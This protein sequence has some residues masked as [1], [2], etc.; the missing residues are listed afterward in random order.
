MATAVS[1]R[2]SQSLHKVKR[3][4]PPSLQTSINAVNSSN[5]SPS[6]SLPKKTPSGLKHPPNSGVSNSI[7]VNSGGTRASGRQ[8]KEVQRPGEVYGR[9]YK[10]SVSGRGGSVDGID[11]DRRKYLK[12]LPPQ[13]YGKHIP[14]SCILWF[15]MLTAR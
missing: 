13:P 10:G 14:A 11:L 2:P 3:P 5:S 15:L 8:R 9:Q 1:A 6:P 4:P 7:T 12:K